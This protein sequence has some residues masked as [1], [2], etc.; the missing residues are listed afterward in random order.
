[1]EEIDYSDHKLQ[2]MNIIE[3]DVSDVEGSIEQGTFKKYSL[4]E[5]G[6]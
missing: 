6:S 3:D 4:E 5:N 2:T 1:L